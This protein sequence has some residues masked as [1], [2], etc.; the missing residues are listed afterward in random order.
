MAVTKVLNVDGVKTLWNKIKGMFLLKKGGIV[1]GDLYVQGS[2]IKTIGASRTAIFA[3]NQG[4]ITTLGNVGIG[5][6][7]PKAYNLQVKESAKI[8]QMRDAYWIEANKD[9]G[10]VIGNSSNSSYVGICTDMVGFD[11]DGNDNPT[12]DDYDTT[13][14]ISTAGGAIFNNVTI[15]SNLYA[16]INGTRYKLDA[17]KAISLGLLVKG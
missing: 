17:A 2:L 16:T 4:G 15:K 6:D 13:W 3:A 1:T 10:L 8:P 9:Q 7:T 12:I 5:V 14:T 11:A